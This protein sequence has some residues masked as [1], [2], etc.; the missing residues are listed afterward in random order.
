[1]WP[2]PRGTWFHEL[3]EHARSAYL[4]AVPQ[5]ALRVVDGPVRRVAELARRVA[6]APAYVRQR[7]AVW[8]GTCR[9]E[10]TRIALWGKPGSPRALFQLVFDAPPV[11]TWADHPRTLPAVLRDPTAI[12][13]DADL[14]LAETTPA[15]AGLFRRRGFLIVPNAVWYGADVGVVRAALVHPSNSLSSDLCRVRRSRYRAERWS[16]TPDDARLFYER[17]VMAHAHARFGAGAIGY[18][19]EEFTR[20]VR[21]GTLIAVRRPEEALP[22]AMAL[23][24][25]RGGTSW[26]VA[27]GTRDGD[28]AIVEAG[29]FAAIYR[30]AIAFADEQGARWIDCGQCSPWRGDGIGRYKA[31]W[32]FH[33]VPGFPLTLEYGVKVVRPASA[34]AR[35]LVEEGLLVRAGR[36]IVELGRARALAVQQAS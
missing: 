6:V 30:A 21:A 20:L 31:K 18:E 26:F 28:R 14:L 27:V 16:S 13:A 2:P 7:C 34:A 29:G 5:A 10:P 19:L 17:Y 33:P 1:M 9:G 12:A 8:T 23:V 22:D 32:G 11:A 15:F 3:Q 25:M 4:R 35:V 24:V 36:A